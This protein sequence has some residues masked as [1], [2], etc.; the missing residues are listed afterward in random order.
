MLKIFQ[1][2]ILTA[3][4]FLFFLIFFSGCSSIRIGYK[5]LDDYLDHQADKY[6]DLNSDQ[7]K[8]VSKWSNDFKAWHRAN[9]VPV[10]IKKIDEVL[11]RIETGEKFKPEEI[12]T[13]IHEIRDRISSY[14]DKFIPDFVSFL[15]TVSD[16]QIEHLKEAY[17]DSNTEISEKLEDSDEDLLDDRKDKLT[18]DLEDWFGTVSEEQ[19]EAVMKRQEPPRKRIEARLERRK[20]NQELFL[21]LLQFRNDPE[22]LKSE[23]RAY[24]DNMIY[25]PG[26]Q[27]SEKDYAEFS[28]GFLNGI[29]EKQKK[30]LIK[31]LKSYRAD[32]KSLL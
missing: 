18:E 30:N 10:Y 4:L 24:T 5:F 27:D 11:T 19:M 23:L 31:K 15:G 8:V 17:A 6:F 20:K 14:R 13:L 29:N 2:R 21:E 9:E 25:V 1:S 28:A 3:G 26:Y 32:F 22:K 7:D 16:K 12:V